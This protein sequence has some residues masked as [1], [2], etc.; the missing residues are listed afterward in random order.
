MKIRIA[1]LWTAVLLGTSLAGCT[2]V[3]VNPVTAENRMNHICIQE[4]PKVQV[5]DFVS[6]MQQG[7]QKHGITSQV[8]GPDVPA[9]CTYISTYTARRSWDLAPYLST[10]QIDIYR[11]GRPIASA[12]Y[13]LRGKGGFALT[14]FANTETKIL[15]VIDQ[16]LGQAK[17][18][19]QVS[20]TR[21]PPATAIAEGA[22]VDKTAQSGLSEKLAAL[23]QALE[24]GLIT[25]QEY[26][27][28]R[29]SLISNL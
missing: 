22:P 11:D 26:E 3:Q 5:S 16:L 27:A 4:N 7:F 8:V 25:Q 10:A 19:E 24:N 9:D 21:I 1:A 23:K 20:T 13:H 29:A 18:P 15:P 28:K 17:H 6:V 2:A 12:M 14:K